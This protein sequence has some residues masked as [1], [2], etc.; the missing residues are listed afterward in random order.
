M[1]S[2]PITFTRVITTHDPESGN[3]IFDKSVDSNVPFEGFPVPT[4]KPPTSDYALAYSTTT[5]P[6][7][8]LSPHRVETPEAKANQDIKQYKSSL[9][10]LSPLNPAGGTACTIVEVPYGNDIAMHRTVSLDYGVIIDGTTELVLDSGEKKT[11][12]K[13]DVFIQRG[14]AH[15]WRNLTKQED[16]GGTLR[17]FFVF[18]PIEKIHVKGGELDQDLT[19]G[20]K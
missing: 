16:N 14:T 2:Y 3:A 13:G 19:L 6:V 20:L 7:E 8:G 18:Q 17:I 5:F 4:G 12:K 1:A 10:N 15:A 9:Q 11:L